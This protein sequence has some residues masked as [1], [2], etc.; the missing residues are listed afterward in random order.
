MT[1]P[2]IWI[3]K[4][5]G[6]DIVRAACVASV[7][8]D[9]NGNITARMSCGDHAAVTLVLDHGHNHGRTPE[10]F[11]RRLLKVVAELSDAAEPAIVRPVHDTERG[12]RWVTERL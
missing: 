7:G 1:P 5:D 4:D 12:W 8:R 11:H 3:A 9:Y 2:E 6:S 10:D